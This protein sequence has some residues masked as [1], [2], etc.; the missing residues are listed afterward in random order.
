MVGLQVPCVN[1]GAWFWTGAPCSPSAYMGQKRWSSNA[2]TSCMTALARSNSLV[3]RA[4]A[5]E[6]PR[7]VF[8]GPCTLLRTWGTRPGTRAALVTQSSSA[9]CSS[10]AE[11]PD[12]GRGSRRSL[13]SSRPCGTGCSQTPSKSL[14]SASWITNVTQ[15][16]AVDDMS[17]HSLDSRHLTSLVF[18]R[19]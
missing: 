3:R 14:I 6:G 5:F 9:T 13:F 10:Q 18:S 16:R 7:P 11:P 8:F 2:F 17:A 4:E 1:Y 19:K 15:E 12:P